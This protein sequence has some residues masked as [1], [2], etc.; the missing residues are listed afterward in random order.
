MP[1]P[2]GKTRLLPF[3]KPALCDGQTL[4]SK[5]C[6]LAF[7]FCTAWADWRALGTPEDPQP[8]PW[9]PQPLSCPPPHTPV[10]S[11]CL[12]EFSRDPGQPRGALY[13]YVCAGP[14]GSM[15][16]YPCVHTVHHPSTCKFRASLDQKVYLDISDIG[17]THALA[18]VG[19]SGAHCEP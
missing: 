11:V 9:Q 19:D 8:S 10:K 6:L 16:V 17:C 7:F 2:W 13:A 15:F 1:I 4:K 18:C 3:L 14:A 12:G 5:E